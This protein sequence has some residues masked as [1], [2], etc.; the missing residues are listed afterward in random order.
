MLPP[1]SLPVSFLGSTPGRRPLPTCYTTL[2]IGE[3]WRCFAQQ[4]LSGCLLKDLRAALRRDFTRWI[5]F[6]RL[7]SNNELVGKRDYFRL[8]S[9]QSLKLAPHWNIIRLILG[10]IHPSWQSLGRQVR[11]DY[12]PKLSSWLYRHHFNVTNLKSLIFMNE[13]LK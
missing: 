4:D 3:D 10:L 5:S 6:V 9:I 8:K 1:F 13:T 12:L 2:S 7:L 11:N